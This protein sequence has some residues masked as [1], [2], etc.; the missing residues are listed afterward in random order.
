MKITSQKTIYDQVVDVTYEY[1]GPA[2]KRFVDREIEAHLGKKPKDITHD[3]IVKLHDW[4]KMAVAFLTDD[5][6]LIDDFSRN[7]LA[8]TDVNGN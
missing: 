8:I 4:S 2:A 6:E 3:D 7:L 1:L 5:S